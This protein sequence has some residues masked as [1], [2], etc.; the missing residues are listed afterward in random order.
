MMPTNSLVSTFVGTNDEYAEN[1]S[2]ASKFNFA[3]VPKANPLDFVNDLKNSKGPESKIANFK[4]GTTTL[5]FV[6]QG[7]VLIA[8][9]SRASMGQFDSSEVVRKVIEINNRMLGTMAGGA[10]D[11]MFWEENL[12]RQVK[13]YE[14]NYGEQLSVSAASKLFS[15]M[16]LQYKNSGLSVGT[17]IAGSDSKGT[18][19]YYCDNDGSRVKGERFAVGSGG[20]YAYGVLDT[21]Y[22]YDLTLEEAV[23]LGKRAISEATFMD[24]GSGGVVRVYHVHEGGWTKIVEAEDNNELIWKHRQAN[25]VSFHDKNLI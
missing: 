12:A 21:Y 2:F 5:G 24:S 1:K 13:L 15:N 18:H 20:T 14:L 9:D 6:F 16:L 11:C 25:G 8:V 10:A 19:L 23:E 22:R 17:M 7:G 4:K 3:M